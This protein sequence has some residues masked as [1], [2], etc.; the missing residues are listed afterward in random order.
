MKQALLLSIFIHIALVGVVAFLVALPKTEPKPEPVHITVVAL[1]PIKEQEKKYQK[2]ESKPTP[3][4]IIESMPT[5]VSKPIE[6]A[7]MPIPLPKPIEVATP[8]TIL[9]PRAVEVA[10]PAPLQK[11]VSQAP[12][13]SVSETKE[14]KNEYLA[15]IRQTIDER[16]I[17]PKNAKKLG[18]TGTAEVTFTILSDGTITAI[19]LSGSSGFALL[20]NAALQILTQLVKVKPIPK[21]LTKTSWEITIPIEYILH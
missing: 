7:Q 2:K 1:A 17:Y 3:K 20:D 9:P 5:P 13:Y 16:K 4:K 6:A 18:Q 8:T 14:A 12:Q 15:H 21:E 19:S 11:K 10:T